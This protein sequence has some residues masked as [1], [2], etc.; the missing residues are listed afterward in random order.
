MATLP[1]TEELKEKYA[2]ASS[3]VRKYI[4]SD[5]LDE[6]VGAIKNSYKLHLDETEQLNTAL[7]AVFLGVRPAAEFPELL[8][9]ALEQNSSAYDAVL[10]DVNEKI[11]VAFRRKMQEPEAPKPSEATPVA[12]K[13]APSGQAPQ[14][15]AQTAPSPAGSIKRIGEQVMKQAERVEVN[16]LGVSAPAPEPKKYP[17]TDP[18]RESI[19]EP[20][21]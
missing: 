17:T 3:A 5:E 18:Y 14:G 20:P 19:D 10:R 6:A 4:A 7:E 16:T 1:T 21:K 13:V 11:F 9:V 2:T 12:I 15:A 8:K